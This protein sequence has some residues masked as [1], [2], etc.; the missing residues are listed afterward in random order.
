MF[1]S[2]LHPR[3][4]SLRR[5]SICALK[6]ETL[7]DSFQEF[8]YRIRSLRLETDGNILRRLFEDIEEDNTPL[9]IK[10]KSIYLRTF[11]YLILIKIKLDNTVYYKDNK[12]RI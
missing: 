9:K 5:Q 6:R 1:T 11:L 8:R 3:W 10:N 7:P 2:M 12:Y 4:L